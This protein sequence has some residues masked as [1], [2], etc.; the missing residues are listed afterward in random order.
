MS[1]NSLGAW[2][3]PE[4]LQML[5]ATTARFMKTEVKPIDDQLPHDSI[6]TPKHLLDP[7]RA[8]AKALGLWALKSPVEYG[9][10]G[11]Y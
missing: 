11:Q 5:Q 2:E 7:L 9:G 6:C 3:M 1:S 4:E 8:K 10:A